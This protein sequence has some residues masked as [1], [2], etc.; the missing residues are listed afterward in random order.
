MRNS[1]AGL[2]IEQERAIP[3]DAAGI[4]LQDWIVR[5][6]Y[7]HQGGKRINAYDKPLHC[8]TIVRPDKPMLL[9]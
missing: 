8:I 1:S 6:K 9:G 5:F 4:V 2:Q 7:K 3:V